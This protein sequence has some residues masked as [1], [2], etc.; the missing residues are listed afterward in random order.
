MELVNR[1]AQ[2]L[3]DPD[4]SLARAKALVDELGVRSMIMKTLK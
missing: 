1:A 3:S 4:L 2:I